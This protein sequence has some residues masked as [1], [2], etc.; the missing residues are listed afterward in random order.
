MPYVII[1]LYNDLNNGSVY[2]ICIRQAQSRDINKIAKIKADGWKSAYKGIVDDGFLNSMS[3]SKQIDMIKNYSSDTMFVAEKDNEVLGFCRIYDYNEPVYDD[4]EIDCEIREIYVNPSFK[5]MG[6]GSA[7]FHFTKEYFSQKGKWKLY[8]GCLKDN[9]SARKFYEKMGGIPSSGKE[10]DIG[11]KLYPIVDF[12][13]NLNSIYVYHVVTEKPMYVGQRIAFDENRHNGVWQRVNE[14]IDIVN[15]IYNNPEKY[16]NVKLEHHTSVALRE[17]ALEK[18]R[19]RKY[20]NYPS[21]M[22]CL[23]VSKTLEEA[24]KWF[25]YFV[26]LDRP[27]LQIVKLKVNG[28][29]FYGDATK[30]FDGRLT[31]KENFILAEKYWENK[32]FDEASIA[33][34]L[35]DGNIEVVEI[36][37]ECRCTTMKISE[38]KIR[39]FSEP[40]YADKDIMHN[41]WHID[42]VHKWLD[43]LIDEYKYDVDYNAL[44]SALYFHGF[45][46]SDQKKI[47]K[48]L[49]ENGLNDSEIQ[50]IVKIAWESQRPETPKTLEGKLLHDAHVLEGGKTYT[51]VKTLITGS[52]R[53]QSLEQT[54]DFM[55]NNVLDNNKCFLPETIKLCEEMN[56]YTNRF[57]DDLIKGI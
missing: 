54:L 57:Y 15:D 39:E 34:M 33:E 45:I 48:W 8:L 19:L 50:K 30:C 37:K 36:V 53:G 26:S 2:M 3:V 28:N 47:E 55:K 35:V 5:R 42:L 6:I 7:L 13:Y 23:Y 31:K 18:V 52:V 20:P 56:D 25:D 21:R 16:M 40:Y 38:E 41:M 22:A 12:M 27:T 17:L 14:K 43:K 24:E 10:I 32:D 4:K 29:M 9:H 1:K 51:V 49:A 11:G 46:Y 44:L